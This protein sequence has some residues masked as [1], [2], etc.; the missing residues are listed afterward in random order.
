MH[1][2]TSIGSWHPLFIE[3]G[4]NECVESSLNFVTKINRS[5]DREQGKTTDQKLVSVLII[6]I[7][8]NENRQ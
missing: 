8:D 5:H 2:F 4:R 6:L 7:Y 3:E 1:A